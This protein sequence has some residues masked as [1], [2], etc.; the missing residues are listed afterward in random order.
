MENLIINKNIEGKA[1]FEWI[2]SAF[3]CFREQPLHFILLSAI[4][5]G[6]GLL[7]L[8]SAFMSPLF[9]ARFAAIAKGIE[10]G[11]RIQIS[12]L[13]NNFFANQTLVRLAFLSFVLVAIIITSMSL[14]GREFAVIF[15][16]PLSILL[17]ALWLSPVI[18]L[19]NPEIQPLSAMWLSIQFAI[20]N[21]PV[22][23]MFSIM[24]LV[25]TLLAILP[26]GLGLII[27]VPVLNITSYY[28][29]K[30]AFVRSKS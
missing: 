20:Y 15:L 5:I 3:F 12:E 2:R 1:S 23:F 17:L 11:E 13:F 21:V 4:F 16:L 6:I 18:C 8:F 10:N 9:N 30:Y 26:L 25:F 24:V 27:W 7:P 22:V 29:Y 14:V 19:Y 28:I